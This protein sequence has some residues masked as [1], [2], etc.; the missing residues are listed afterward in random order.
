MRYTTEVLSSYEGVSKTS[1]ADSK[2]VYRFH[3]LRR[4]ELKTPRGKIRYIETKTPRD[5]SSVHTLNASTL[6]KAQHVNNIRN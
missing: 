2:I 6:R 4:L 1:I 5:A 3:G